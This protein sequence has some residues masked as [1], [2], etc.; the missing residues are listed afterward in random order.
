M[1]DTEKNLR[2]SRRDWFSGSAALVG[3]G[4]ISS[5]LLKAQTTGTTALTNDIN[6][7]N[8]AL[9]LENLENAFY[10]QAL[11]KFSPANFTGS[12]TVS[13]IG[14]T[15]IGTNLYSYIQA[16]A[17]EE[18]AHVS[19]LIQTIA[20]MGGTPQPIDCYNF[21][22]TTADNFIQT[23]QTLENTGVAAYDGIIAGL[24][25]AAN[26]TLAATIA[27]VEARHAAYL[28]VLN[29]SLP[30]PAPF[31]TTQ[32]MSQVMLTIM[33]YL[34]TG[35]AVP[36]TLLTSAQ[37]GPTKNAIITTNQTTVQLNG[38]KLTSAN[39]LPLTYS[40]ES[41]LGSP[42][43]AILDDQFPMAMAILMA[44]AGE[45]SITLKV[46]DTQGN[47]DQDQLKIIYQP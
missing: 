10:S 37:A 16:I 29:L 43:A 23:A 1:T 21:G 12:Q 31:D 14:G 46:T 7:L 34:T 13:T 25:I 3:A 44:G 2:S 32:T 38:S 27:T 20:A 41:D 11:A 30:F 28:N 22:M 15:K 24:M 47:S 45:Y 5:L 35:C 39:G 26:Q 9:R 42:L 36:P 40:W 18:Q 33:N 4:A 6:L 17:N 19:T 8:F